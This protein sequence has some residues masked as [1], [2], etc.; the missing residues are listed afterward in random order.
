MEI[1]GRLSGRF[2]FQIIEL[3]HGNYCVKI[4]RTSIKVVFYS[5]II[6]FI[7]FIECYL[8]LFGFQICYTNYYFIT[9]ANNSYACNCFY[10]VILQVLRLY[11]EKIG[12]ANNSYFSPKDN[13]V[14]GKKVFLFPFYCDKS[15]N[16]RF[17]YSQYV[18]VSVNY[19][20]NSTIVEETSIEVSDERL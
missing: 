20:V 5:S 9:I 19:I 4:L 6:D 17:T 1:S 10:L 8:M 15:S 7:L 13:Y 3:H 16:F 2:S 12:N 11:T 18:Y 14:L